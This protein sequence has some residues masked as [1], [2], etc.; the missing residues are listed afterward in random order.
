MEDLIKINIDGGW[1][2]KANNNDETKTQM[3]Q[4]KDHF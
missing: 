2:I 4:L 1:N 3:M